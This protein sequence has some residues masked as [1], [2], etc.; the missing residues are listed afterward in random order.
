MSRIITDNYI[1]KLNEIIADFDITPN[2]YILMDFFIKELSNSKNKQYRIFYEGDTDLE[3]INQIKESEKIRRLFS[4]INTII[5]EFKNQYLHIHINVE[6]SG[7]TISNLLSLFV[8]QALVEASYDEEILLKEVNN[9]KEKIKPNLILPSH[10][11][12]IINQ[13]YKERY[14]LKHRLKFID[15]ILSLPKQTAKYGL[16]LNLNRTARNCINLS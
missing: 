7:K 16:L 9:I 4:Y 13:R 11:Q 5:N 3:R 10:G 14:G 6:L 8:W 15:T 2:L 1:D 12:I